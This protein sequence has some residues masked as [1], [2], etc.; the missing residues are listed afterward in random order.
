MSAVR[1]R[2]ESLNSTFPSSRSPPSHPTTGQIN[3]MPPQITPEELHRTYSAYTVPAIRMLTPVFLPNFT[4]KKADRDAKIRENWVRTMEARL[5]REELQKC[6]K[7]EGVNHYQVCNYLTKRYL[8]L[9]EDA[10]VRRTQG[11]MLVSCWVADSDRNCLHRSRDSESSTHSP[12][13]QYSCDYTLGR[14]SMSG[15]EMCACR[16]H[17]R[18]VRSSSFDTTVAL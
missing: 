6:H 1:I 9:L 10:K 3:T 16:P 7:A 8:A 18:A 13:F 4:E 2:D 14:K 17:R 11:L 5:V 15:D 12:R